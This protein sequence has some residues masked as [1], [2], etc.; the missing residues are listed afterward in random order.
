MTKKLIIN[1]LLCLAICFTASCTLTKLVWEDKKYDEKITQFFVGADGRY[2]VLVSANYHYIFTDNSGL[3]KEVLSLKQR[4]V[5]TI[6][7]D[8]TYLKLKS[9][10]EIKGEFVIS[11]P[12]SIL[13]A[14][15]KVVLT[16]F[17]FKPDDNDD[18]S[19]VIR[20]TGRRY[21]AKYLG[22]GAPGPNINYVI[23]IYYN[24]STLAKDVGKAAI[25]PITVTLDTALLIGKIIVYPLS[26]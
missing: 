22:Q 6:N 21:V 10:N 7:I 11:G 3:F 2:I 17:G 16:R 25:T 1:F 20:L 19:V 18:I 24:D 15:D 23:P 13:P 4:G 8:E 5:L 12:Y 14:E 26:W 9:N